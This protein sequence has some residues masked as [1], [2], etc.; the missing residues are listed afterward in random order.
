LF[1]RREQDGEGNV[2]P[3]LTLRQGLRQLPVPSV[4]ADFD[5][6]IHLA[7]SRRKS[8][9]RTVWSSLRPVLAATSASLVISLALL[10][11]LDRANTGVV[12]FEF[13]RGSDPAA[14]RLAATCLDELER[15]SGD[16]DQSL[17][18]FPTLGVRGV[19]LPMK[20]KPLL[21][22]RPHS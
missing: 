22:G 20:T 17:S 4:S 2:E 10:A 11:G 14:T 16:A 3:H 19:V 7:L 6:K 15:G 1:R 12:R 8:D 18:G 5:A 13:P 9:W 21:G